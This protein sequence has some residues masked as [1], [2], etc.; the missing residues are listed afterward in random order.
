MVWTVWS[1]ALSTD[2]NRSVVA[3]IRAYS[4]RRS[5]GA[6]GPLIVMEIRPFAT[7]RGAVAHAGKYGCGS[8]YP[9]VVTIRRASHEFPEGP[10]GS[11]WRSGVAPPIV[12]GAPAF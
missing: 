1:S 12:S 9:D 10:G 2:A 5:D 7:P 4:T 6:A 3:R 8:P 11:R